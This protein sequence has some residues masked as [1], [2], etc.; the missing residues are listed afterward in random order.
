MNDTL[1][2]IASRYSCR[3]YTGEMP[4]DGQLKAIAEAAIQSPSGMN[5]QPWRI[6][7]LKNSDLM[8]ELETEGLRILSE[9]EDK[10]SFNRIMERGGKLYYNAP[11]MIIVAI[12]PAGYGGSQLDCGIVCENIALAAQSLSLG[13]VICGFAGFSFMQ[14]KKDY[15]KKKLS[16]PDTY[17]IGCAVLI[18]YPESDGEPHQPDSSKITF[19]D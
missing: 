8:G 15:F 13:S 16:F 17:E 2:T 18:G 12:D 10:S 7:V 1:K 3:T 5:A 4:S 6:I 11:C 9:M 19:I 14:G